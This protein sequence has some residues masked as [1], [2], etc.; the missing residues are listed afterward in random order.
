MEEMMFQ[1]PSF[2]FLINDEIKF[3]RMPRICIPVPEIQK[4]YGERNPLS[5]ESQSYMRPSFGRIEYEAIGS[6]YRESL[7]EICIEIRFNS[8]L[9]K[10]G[11][12][13]RVISGES[14]AESRSESENFM[15]SIIRDL[16]QKIYREIE[17]KRDIF[18]NFGWKTIPS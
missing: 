3:Y 12:I 17:Y 8:L 11:I 7:D 2:I 4:V 9:L 14:I 10:N 1:Y 16:V 18:I 13:K 5:A 6:I 15:K